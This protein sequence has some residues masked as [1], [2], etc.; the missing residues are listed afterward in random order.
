MKED[1]LIE[2]IITDHIKE[3]EARLSGK[4]RILELEVLVK[5][6]IPIGAGLGSSAAYSIAVAGALYLA[7]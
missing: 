3:L 5:S 4:K 7:V 6:E 2:K 1:K